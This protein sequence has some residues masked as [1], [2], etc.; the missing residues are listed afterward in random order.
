[1]LE[2]QQIHDLK[3][4]HHTLH[5]R[6]K[7]LPLEKGERSWAMVEFYTLR[8]RLGK[9]EMTFHELLDQV[10]ELEVGFHT[11]DSQLTQ[12]LS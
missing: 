3:E 4:L 12:L 2:E 1:M 7:K 9:C 11:F 6:I 10:S 5:L 8:A